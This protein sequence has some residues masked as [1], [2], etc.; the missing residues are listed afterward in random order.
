MDIRT[1]A[2]LFSLKNGMACIVLS[3]SLPELH[4]AIDRQLS[5]HGLSHTKVDFF[6]YTGYPE[7]YR[8]FMPG[9][10]GWLPD[11][12]SDFYCHDTLPGYMFL[13]TASHQTCRY[14]GY[15]ARK[16]LHVAI[17]T[18][19]FISERSGVR[20]S[21][22]IRESPRLV[23]YPFRYAGRNG[24]AVRLIAYCFLDGVSCG[25]DDRA[26]AREILR[27]GAKWFCDHVT[28]DYDTAFPD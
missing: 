12:S 14:G 3:G 6:K 11:G 8:P 16:C 23:R 5:K 2:A 13:E 28:V 27:N 22:D 1:H 25:T 26:S 4:T 18:L 10:P 15:F 21:P 17:R 19:F 9:T 7:E 24:S 20:F